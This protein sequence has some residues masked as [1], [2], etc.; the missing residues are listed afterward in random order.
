VAFHAD[1]E[2][3]GVR[4]CNAHHGKDFRW[5]GSVSM[6]YKSLL[7]RKRHAKRNSFSFARLLLSESSKDSGS[8]NFKYK[9]ETLLTPL[10]SSSSYKSCSLFVLLTNVRPY[11]AGHPA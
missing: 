2:T 1:S 5:R 7:V 4:D 6:K 3:Q 11:V 9:G 10:A 8:D